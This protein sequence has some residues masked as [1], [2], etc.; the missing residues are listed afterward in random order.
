MSALA[1]A[2]T[3]RD[4]IAAE[5]AG[6]PLQPNY[7]VGGRTFDHQG[8]RRGLMEDLDKAQ[9]VVVLL[10]GAVEIKQQALG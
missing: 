5:L 8:H 9:R 4:K 7:S 10:T 3:Y 6:L 2:I 1:D